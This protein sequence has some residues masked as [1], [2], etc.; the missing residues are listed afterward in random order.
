MYKKTGIA[1]L[2]AGATYLIFRY[3]ASMM[4]WLNDSDS[5]L[6]VTALAT[7]LALFPVIPYPIVGGAIGAAFGPAIGGL[8]T[9]IGSAAA[10]ILMFLFVR[11][12]YQ[13]WGS[14][15]LR[16]YRSL[17]KL[18]EMFERSAFLTIVFAR[19]VPFIPSIVTNVYS[20]LSRV[21]FAVYAIASSLGKIPPMV[22]FAVVGD[23]IANR[24]AQIAAIIA[25]YAA[26]FALTWWLHRLWRRRQGLVKSSPD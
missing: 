20:A 16:R 4:A 3:G 25:G 13:E 18:T 1:L 5:T 12:G 21:P 10:S 14:R 24:P 15:L 17:D 6:L 8:I 11:Y 23:S 19:L 9:W 2:Y 26:F 7:I 22:L